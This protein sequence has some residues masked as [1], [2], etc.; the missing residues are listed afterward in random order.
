MFYKELTSANSTSLK[1]TSLKPNTPYGFKV[2]A[3]KDA[4]EGETLIGEFS[5]ILKTATKPEE[6]KIKTASSPSS[7]KIKV[8]YSKVSCNG[9]QVRWSTT[10]NFSSNHKSVYVTS[11]SS[12]TKTVTAA[13]S[14]KAYY[15]KVRAYRNVNGTKLYSSWSD[16]LRVVTK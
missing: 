8:T 9:Y 6:P 15:V 3:I 13:Q 4:A 5:S 1:V 2:R 10:K 16:T 14:K 7:K 11:P 12:L